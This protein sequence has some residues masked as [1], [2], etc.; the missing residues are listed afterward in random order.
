MSFRVVRLIAGRELRDLFRDRRSIVLL[1]CLPI[2]LYPGFGLVGYL[3]AL[4]QLEHR[5]LIGVV[6]LDALPAPGGEA[7]PFHTQGKLSEKY[8]DLTTDPETLVLISVASTDEGLARLKSRDADRLDVLM[9]VHQDAARNYAAGQPFTIELK[10]R[11]GDDLSKLSMRR[12]AKAIDRFHSALRVARFSSRQL[13]LDFDICINV[14]EPKDEETPLQR[15]SDEIRDRLA[16]FLPFLLVMWALAGAL[17]PAIDLCAGEKERG[18]METL[19]ISPAERVEIVAGK[20]AAVWGYATLTAWWNLVWMGGLCVLGSWYLGV[21]FVRPSS[22]LLCYVLAIPL[23]ALFA[24]LCLALGVYARSTKEGQYYLLP[25]FL[26]VMPLV[27][28][29]LMPG[30]ELTWKTS[31]IPVSG[32]CLLMQKLLGPAA[33]EAIPYVPLVLGAMIVCVVLS[34]AWAVRQFHREDVLFRE[35]D[36]DP[37]RTWLQGF[38]GSSS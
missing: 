6:S 2:I 15:G 34:A 29:S 30:I 31:L 1:F 26:G 24:A 37:I 17:H 22:V 36:G 20:F 28:V 25:L 33:S 10:D 27:L 5:S 16:K 4:S 21:D 9:V 14:R 13:P 3:F 8:C 18:T 19:L 35:S 32:V 11:E 12:L 38:G 7:P 23:T